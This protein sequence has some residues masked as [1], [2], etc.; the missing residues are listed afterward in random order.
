MFL[1]IYWYIVLA[2][3]GNVTASP[4]GRISV[5]VTA[6]YQYDT[7]YDIVHFHDIRLMNYFLGQVS[8]K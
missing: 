6:T 2:T 5:M 3:L 7:H 8:A 4:G 1:I